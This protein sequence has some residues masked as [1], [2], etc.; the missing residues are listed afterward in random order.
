MPVDSQSTVAI[1]IGER[2]GHAQ[3]AV[4]EY[5]VRH[6]RAGF[7]PELQWGTHPDFAV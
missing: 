2:V 1:E 3:N 5:R 6:H 7:T 4:P